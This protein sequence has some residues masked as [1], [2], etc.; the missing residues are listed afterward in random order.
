MTFRIALN[1]EDGATRFV[2]C[3]DGEKVLDAAYRNQINLP[4][5]CSDGVCGT[6]KCRCEQG[7]YDLGDDYIEDALTEEEAAEGL[8]LT[9]Q[10]VPSSDCVI[11]VPVA[12]TAC[13]L[14]SASVEVEVV[15]VERL[16]ANR[17]RL[18]VKA[19]NKDNGGGK[20]PEFLPGQYVNLVVPGGDGAKRSYSFS[21]PSGAE[22]ATFLIRNVTGG[23]MGAYLDERAKA[24]DRMA[25]HGPLGAFYLRAAVRPILMLAGGT[26][27]AP[28]LAMLE[29]L[30]QAGTGGQ[31]VHLVYGVHSAEDLVELERLEALKAKLPGFTFLATCS[32]PETAYPVKGH[33]DEQI[34]VGDLKGGDVDVYVCGPPGMVEAVRERIAAL[35]AAPANFYLEKFIPSQA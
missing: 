34:I 35:G 14:A 7:S 9:C 22:V 17:T 5:D 15:A 23:A 8:V 28:M 29:T 11:Q 30:A 13:K 4:M 27:V 10:M 32:D 12:S 19:A 21:S 3:N 26:G 31:P 1:F 24:G 18:S 33:V 20:L 2:D 6:C 16:S 25:L